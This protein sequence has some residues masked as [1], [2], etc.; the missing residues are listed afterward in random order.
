MSEVI[1][2][3][4]YGKRLEDLIVIAQQGKTVRA[5]VELRKIPLAQKVHPD[6][7]NDRSGELDTYL[8]IGDYVFEV[9]GESRIETPLAPISKTYMFATIGESNDARRMN[10][11]IAN[12]RLRM[13]YQR[14][15]NANIE[16]EEMYF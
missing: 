13:D 10:T 14:L 1:Q 8:L 7:S 12:A 11:N 6:E 16:I 4:E 15:Q 3:T 2:K 5:K 9:E